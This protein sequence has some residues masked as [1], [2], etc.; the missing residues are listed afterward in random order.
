MISEDVDQET[1][2]DVGG[3]QED[4]NVQDEDGDCSRNGE[5][6]EPGLDMVFIR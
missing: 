4:D 3:G 1:K 6:D 2:S 5:E